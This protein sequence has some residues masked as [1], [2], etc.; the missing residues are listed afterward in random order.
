MLKKRFELSDRKSEIIVQSSNKG[1]NG[2]RLQ[3]FMDESF[4]DEVESFS[5]AIL[6]MFRATDFQQ[7]LHRQLCGHTYVTLGYFISSDCHL[8]FSFRNVAYIP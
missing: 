5:E 3:S 7:L 2:E 8:Y 6:K 4:E 1:A